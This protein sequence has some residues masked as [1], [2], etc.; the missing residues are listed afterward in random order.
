MFLFG[1]FKSSNCVAELFGTVRRND[2]C[3]K[4]V[5]DVSRRRDLSNQ[6]GT[7]FICGLQT[8]GFL[9]WLSERFHC[10]HITEPQKSPVLAL[11]YGLISIVSLSN[12]A[13]WGASSDHRFWPWSHVTFATHLCK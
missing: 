5:V 1:L 8:W 11:E 9:Q 6:E 12:L 10:R 3:A 2:F 13:P 7:N 4:V